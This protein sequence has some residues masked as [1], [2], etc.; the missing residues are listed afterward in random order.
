MGVTVSKTWSSV[1]SPLVYF[2]QVSQD[3]TK[4]MLSY[5]SRATGS[6]SCWRGRS[7]RRKPGLE[8]CF[9][10]LTTAIFSSGL[11]GVPGGF[12]Y[13]ASGGCAGHNPRNC[14]LSAKPEGCGIIP[15]EPHKRPPRLRPLKS[16]L[17]TKEKVS[18]SCGGQLVSQSLFVQD[19]KGG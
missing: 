15:A 18:D 5:F 9:L 11:N 17:C 1:I 16:L 10:P 14:I 13:T 3:L 2:K 6:R 4:C 7:V 19:K 12:V 8:F